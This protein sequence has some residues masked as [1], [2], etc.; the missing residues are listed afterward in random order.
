M[1]VRD[2][3]SVHPAAKTLKKEVYEDY[4]NYCNANGYQPADSA[5][6]G[7]AMKA[8]GIN[9]R[10]SNGKAYYCIEIHELG[11]K[12]FPKMPPKEPKKMLLAD[13]MGETEESEA[14]A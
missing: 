14:V 6:F 5:T 12:P 1:Y 2:C 8:K 11:M 10:D 13:V 9:S 3:V 4:R 7:K